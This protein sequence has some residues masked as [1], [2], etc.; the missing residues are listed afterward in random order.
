MVAQLVQKRTALYSSSN[1]THVSKE[2]FSGTFHAGGDI[3]E[4]Y[5][6]KL[7]DLYY[8]DFYEKSDMIV[9]E[10]DKMLPFIKEKL[11]EATPGTPDEMSYKYLLRHGEYTRLVHIALSLYAKGDEEAARAARKECRE[12]V[13]TLNPEIRDGLDIYQ[14][15]LVTTLHGWPAGLW[16]LPE[17]KEEK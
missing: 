17:K 2:Y 14:Y 13:V 3:I 16:N 11:A 15:A 8:S 5:L 9:A 10:I 4:S 7:S 1:G 6:K 12:Y